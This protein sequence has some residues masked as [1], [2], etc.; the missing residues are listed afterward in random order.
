MKR[1]LLTRFAT[2]TPIVVMSPQICVSIGRGR[3]KQMIAEHKHLVENGAQLVELRIDYIRRAP[4]LKRLLDNRPGPVVFTCRRKSDQGRWEGSEQDRQMLLRSAIVHGVDYID[5][6][7]D[8]AG[9]VPRYG[10]TKR[11]I[12]HH[13]FQ[14]TPD[15]LEAIHESLC[16]H[17]P[18]IV[19]IAVKANSPSDNFRILKM[20]AGSK[21]PTVGIGMGE[22]GVPTRIL[23]G[24][25]GAPFTF[26]TFH[27][28]RTLAPGQLSFE[29]MKNVYRFE[30]LNAETR[31]FGVIADPV[32]HSMSPLIH[33]AAFAETGANAVYVPFRV[34]R[35]DLTEFLEGSRAIGLEGL[36]VTIPHKESVLALLNEMD[37]AV[38]EIGAA[39]TILFS[40]TGL[41]GSNTDAG[42]AMKVLLAGSGAT[43]V[44]KP[45][46][47][48][49]ALVLGSGGVAR[50]L[51]YGLV[52]AGADVVIAA[53]NLPKADLLAEKL[54][55]E[56][57]EWSERYS[58]K[59]DIIVNGTPIGMHPNV[60]DTPYDGAKLKQGQV[61]FDT[62]YNPERTMLVAQARTRGCRVITG[63]D[64][65]CRQAALQF[66]RFVNQPAPEDVMRETIKRAIGA[67]RY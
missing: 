57:V 41:S 19:K 42:A 65:F 32:G 18:D 12:S 31:V 24:K 50:A 67:V 35:E 8:I 52:E 44:E 11:I 14:E 6:E 13:D 29:Q 2:L 17:D 49:K 38:Q 36:S 63:I 9:S 22:I 43:D 56:V 53:R 59:P 64:M 1:P 4:D 61:V 58:V 27:H 37:N 26:A 46:A 39:N 5:L 48:N 7:G 66:E 28:E 16:Q 45:L 21:V 33:N 47:G 55:G 51:V 3:H 62:V 60:D 54:G 30:K 40:Q 23:A 34:P 20:I 10:K 15:N 25:F